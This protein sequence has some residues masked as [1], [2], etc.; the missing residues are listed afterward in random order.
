MENYV[1]KAFVKLI[2]VNSPSPLASSHQQSIN[3]VEGLIYL[4]SKRSLSLQ[5]NEKICDTAIVF[6]KC[7]SRR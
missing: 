5:M 4:Q 2:I 7:K 1:I 3:Q 6:G